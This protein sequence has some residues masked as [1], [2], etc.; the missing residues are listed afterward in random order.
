MARRAPRRRAGA[1]RAAPRAR[2]E[3]NGASGTWWL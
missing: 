2:G 1:G 3:L